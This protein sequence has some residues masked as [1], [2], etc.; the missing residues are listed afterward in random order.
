MN[1]V[2]L[3]LEMHFEG[4][5]EIPYYCPAGLL[6]GGYG[7][8][9]KRGEPVRP[10]PKEEARR[11]LENDQLAAERSTFRLCPVLLIE[12]ESRQGAII[13]FVFNLGGGR[14]QASTLRRRINQRSWPEVGRELRKWVR[15]GGRIL[16]G[17]VLRRESE[18]R[19]VSCH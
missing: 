17:L 19:L 5:H 6:T 16:P 7:H 10:L 14:L 12:S 4:Y 8:A 18:A 3:T 1:K 13:D 11:V 15:G 9:F 2:A